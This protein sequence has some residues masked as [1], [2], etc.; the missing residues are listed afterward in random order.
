M[1]VCFFNETSIVDGRYKTKV[2]GPVWGSKGKLIWGGS[3][4]ASPELLDILNKLLRNRVKD[5][6][7]PSWIDPDSK[8]NF[9]DF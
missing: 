1:R 3:I 6:L 8:R 2:M 7:L 5:V 4:I 9:A